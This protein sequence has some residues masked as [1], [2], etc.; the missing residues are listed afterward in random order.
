MAETVKQ[1]DK[2]YQKRNRKEEN[3]ELKNVALNDAISNGQKTETKQPNIETEQ[4][5]V[6]LKL[7]TSN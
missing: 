5:K 3:R 4:K 2:K 7:E 6:S 1:K